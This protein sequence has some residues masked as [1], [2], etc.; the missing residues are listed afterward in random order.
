MDRPGTTCATAVAPTRVV[1]DTNVCL[2]LFVFDDPRCARLDEALRAGVV[3]AITSVP[4]EEEWRAVLTYPQL[5]LSPAMLVR[6]MDAFS[7]RMT[8]L[9]EVPPAM[10]L[11]RCADPDDQ[12]FL[13]LA[14][15]A[16]AR[17]LLS[18]DRALLMLH[19]RCLRA[20]GFAVT[21]P[22]AWTP[23]DAA[24]ALDAPQGL[25]AKPV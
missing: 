10:R 22:E 6:A 17:W 12:K 15:G 20:A 5:A 25:S 9:P 21:T 23:P 3:E 18:R 16:G 13:A 2:D 8:C 14:A 11:P 4:C 24:V 1:L 7:S 19:R